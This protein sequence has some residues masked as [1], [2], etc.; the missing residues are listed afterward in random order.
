MDFL[1]NLLVSGPCCG[2]M[3]VRAP[4]TPSPEWVR[5]AETELLLLSLGR[6]PLLGLSWGREVPV[7]QGKGEQTAGTERA[8]CVETGEGHHGIESGTRAFPLWP[9]I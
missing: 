3:P 5:G 4:S 1:K 2:G 9:E 8:V 7:P 6:E